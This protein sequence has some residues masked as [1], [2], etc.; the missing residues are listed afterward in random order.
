MNTGSD[1]EALAQ[2]YYSRSD[3][4]SQ[5]LGATFQ[6][7]FNGN[8]FSTRPAIKLD[9]WQKRSAGSFLLG[10]EI[11]SGYLK[12]DSSLVPSV[13]S[14]N[15]S[16]QILKANYFLFGPGAGYGHS[17]VYKKHLF[18]TF[19]AGINGDIVKTKEWNINKSG[20]DK[21]SFSPNYNLKAGLGY[22]S[23]N[24]GLTLTYLTKKNFVKGYRA[25]SGYDIFVNKFRIAF[26]K[27][28]N[29]GKTIPKVVNWMGGIIR[30]IG[31][32][33]FI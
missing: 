4:T 22:N 16:G 24:F 20:H 6:Y 33:F 14:T 31:L 5:V 3:I 1:F 11:Y 26:T 15:A 32:G 28:I 29:S 9:T 19:I 17:F 27:R 2:P 7:T 13:L 12:G 8:K 21:W 10:A 23:E 25:N 18:A 30:S